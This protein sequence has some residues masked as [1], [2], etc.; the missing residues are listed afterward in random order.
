MFAL[1]LVACHRAGPAQTGPLTT[2]DAVLKLSY[3]AASARPQAHLSGTVTVVD[4]FTQVMFVQDRTGA[5]WAT[6]QPGTAVP[7]TGSSVELSGTATAIGQDRALIYPSIDSVRPG[8]QAEPR[9]ITRKDLTAKYKNYLLGRFRVRIKK[10]LASTGREVHF[11]GE[12][13]GGS[14]EVSLLNLP[15]EDVGDFVGQEVDV[16][17][18]PAPPTQVSTAAMP[19]FL[20][21][22]LT[23]PVGAR[24]SPAR[25]K[26]LTTIREI[27]SLNAFEARRSY[28]VEL[29]GVVTTSAPASYMLT[30][31]DETGAIYL[32]STHPDQYPPEGFR[33]R[34]EGTSSPG[35]SVPL[36][37]VSKI[38]VENRAP[39][40]APADL[41]RFRIND[42][43]LDNL[44]VHL[45]GVARSVSPNPSG[46]YQM[47]I[48]TPQF[49][50]TVVVRSGTAVEASRFVPGTAV[51]LEGAYSP[52]SDRFRHWRDFQV[53][54]PSLSGIRIRR[55]SPG[56]AAESQVKDVP[57]R[58]LFDYGTMFSS[59]VPI[60]IRGVVTLGTPD[61]G[62][63]VSDGEGGVQV[64][65]VAGSKMVQPGMLVELV[66]FIP[67]N[68]SQRRLEDATWSVIGA[69]PL[70]EAPI[71]QAASAL[72]GSYES[73]WV[74]LEGRLTHRQQAL[75][76][77]ILVLE[78][79][80]GLVSVYSAGV[81]AAAWQSLRL[82]SD[83]MVRGVVLPSLD[84]TGLT[85]SRTVRMLIGS[86]QDVQVIQ[87]ASWWTPEHLTTYLIIASVF[88]FILFL[89]AAALGARVRRQSRII[90]KKLQM[91]ERLT[92]EAQAASHAKSQFLASMSHEIRTPMHGILGLT[93]LALQ[94][95]GQPAQA[96]YL[97]DAL[98]SA[99]S[100]MGLLN[101][102][103][104]LAKIESGK[105]TL[106][107][108]RF[109][110]ASM[111][112]LV[113]APAI[114]QCK[115]KRV[116]FVCNVAPDVPDMV[117]GDEMRLRQI[118]TNLLS[119]A[120]KFTREGKI[121]VDASAEGVAG[122]CF[123]LVLHVR[124][125]GI[126]IAPE[127]ISRIFDAF[128]QAD[129]SDSRRYGGT[130]LGLAICLK[131]ARLMGGEIEVTSKPGEGSDFRVHLPMRRMPVP[132]A[133]ASSSGPVST[134]EPT[135]PEPVSFRP[136]KILAAEDNRVNRLLL[137]R[138]L[139]K[140]GHQA[141]FAENGIEALRLWENGSFDVLLMDLQM[142][143]MDG[144]E[145][146]REI[147]RREDGNGAHIPIIAVTASAM[148]EDEGLTVAAGMDGYVSK[149]Y[150]AEDILTA[151]Q[152]AVRSRADGASG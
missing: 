122:E 76:H 109:S 118:V 9:Q 151:I 29:R 30:M 96:S 82:G 28:P 123:S 52:R 68:P 8:T 132:T 64:V 32:W 42:A 33:V 58:S 102:V 112:Q 22:S 85:G 129:L 150:S 98:E 51:S 65:P 37:A 141:V 91:E 34:V 139:E 135:T 71:I 97:K 6:L 54:T 66:G 60:H 35:E 140:A 47:A 145:A 99:Q 23:P 10:M 27:K 142:P 152:R 128:E 12:M 36:V 38:I 40:P 14:V 55:S 92:F 116:K 4:Q 87:M 57:L 80:S 75:E 73:R 20:A 121:E 1:G 19:L 146:A 26:L 81:P 2:A 148:R 107:E 134:P 137:C 138:I 104:D 78:S 11:S 39:M 89:F 90:E 15:T 93:E 86:S 130:G 59:M 48:A 50:T 125:T 105:M 88:L 61:G 113:V 110:F 53:Y 149:P 43:R 119:N 24:K 79:T 70:P 49:R 46:G 74:R 117:I 18:V 144:L 25:L 5:V 83:L 13:S 63:Y 17:G 147:R 45:D 101:H 127:N 94:T 84:R 103:L 131:L 56:A 100:L 72:D 133:E 67:N 3:E 120:C 41:A 62:F 7:T 16:A 114:Q 111:L 108:E 21:E 31:Q 124:D 95:V 106:E 115:G 44:W 69:S 126:G 136:L 77:N 143:E